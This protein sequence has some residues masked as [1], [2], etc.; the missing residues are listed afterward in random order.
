MSFRPIAAAAFVLASCNGAELTDTDLVVGDPYDVQVGPYES[1]I[2]WT[3]HG[4]PHIIADDIGSAS[5]AQGYAQAKHHVCNLADMIVK[6]RS[7][8]AMYFGPGRDN[9]HIDSDFG[10]KHLQVRVQAERGFLSEPDYAQQAMIGFSAGYNKYIAETEQLPPACAGADWV[11]PIDH[12]D[13]YSYMYV[14]GQWGSGLAL[15]NV[16]GQAQPPQTSNGQVFQPIAPP[17]IEILR[18]V[19]EPEMGSNGWA[20]GGD[21]SVTGK[22]A[23]LSNTHFPTFGERQWHEVHMTVPGEYNIYGASLIGMPM[24]AMG[25]NEHIAWTHTVSSTP[26]FT[27]YLLQLQP[28]DP[29]RYK[30]GDGSEQ[31]VATDYT[32]QVKQQDGSLSDLQRTLYSSRYGPI[33]NAPVVGWNGLHAMAYRDVNWNNNGMFSTWAGLNRATSMEDFTAV[34]REHQ[35]VP[36]VHTIFAD[37]KGNAMYMDSAATPNISPE[38]W[39]GYDAFAATNF[40]AGQ[41]KSFGLTVLDGTDPGA[42]W[43]DDDRAAR[44]GTVPF[45]DNPQIVRRDFV[46]NANQN[47]W[48]ANP[49]APLTSF[50]RIYGPTGNPP[51]PRTRMNNF[52]LQGRGDAPERGDD[53]KW[54]LEE[55]EAAAMSMR[56]SLSELVKS[57]VVDRCNAGPKSIMVSDESVEMGPIC[58][59][60]DRWD[61]RGNTHSVGAHVW[62]EFLASDPVQDTIF[63]PS[64]FFEVPYDSGDPITTP[65]GLAAAPLDAPD[66]I[67]LAIARGAKRLTDNGFELDSEL[68]DVQVRILGTERHPTPGGSFWE[69]YIAISDWTSGGKTTLDPFPNR[70]DVINNVSDLAEEGYV[71]NYGNSWVMAV[72]FGDDGPKARAVL[73]YS[74]SEDPSSEHYSDQTPLFSAQKMR[75]VL[76]TEEDIL[77]NPD[78]VEQTL[79]LE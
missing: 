56:S 32:I 35:G 40:F 42:A 70:G 59:I 60:L 3:T 69:G 4:I 47:H 28:G 9:V 17:D 14:M 72:Q 67:P 18:F 21:H 55:I 62:R 43:T 37:D 29:T 33:W 1:T 54:A 73:V 78:L 38:T 74:Q 7:E 22:G 75:P 68:G 50:P 57:D 25:F 19:E 46:S 66:P 24:V 34:Q 52:Y 30:F 71:V 63:P 61:G 6:A 79:S 49:D 77:A 44:S 36:W 5:F 2:R 16:V 11:K 31:M 27:P 58:A 64:T 26:R 39:A 76:F 13:L 23:L 41:Y 53:N 48:L 10:W 65:Y 45:D 12:I 8:R 51:T 20:I 15:V